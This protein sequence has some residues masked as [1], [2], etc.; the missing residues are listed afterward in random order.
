[1]TPKFIVDMNAGKLTR[2]LRVLGYDALFI[3]PIDDD[4]LIRMAIS[5]ERAILTRDGH[6]PKRRIVRRHR[7]PVLLL[8]SESWK[9]QLKQVID[10][11]NLSREEHPFA[12]CIRCNEPLGDSETESIKE[13]VPPYVFQTQS[14]F[15]ECPKCHRVFWRGTHWDRMCKELGIPTL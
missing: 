11:F 10:R 6:I 12:R 3:N 8:D 4:E 13:R 7:V 2:W 15:K 5:Q 14:S 1:M 9:E